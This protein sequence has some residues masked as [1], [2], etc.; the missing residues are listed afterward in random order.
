MTDTTTTTTTNDEGPGI[1]AEI[2]RS[3]IIR[4]DNGREAVRSVGMLTDWITAEDAAHLTADERALVEDAWRRAYAALRSLANI[5]QRLDDARE[6]LLDSLPADDDDDEYD[7]GAES[8][9][10]HFASLGL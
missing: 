1:R 9:R 3:L 10:R 7:A 4:V 6:T 8:E 5:G 2:L